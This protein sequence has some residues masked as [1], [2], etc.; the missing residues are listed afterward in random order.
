M[1]EQKPSEE[2]PDSIQQQIAAALA[3]TEVPKIYFNGFINGTTHAD[4]VLI[5][6]SNERPAIVLN[7][8][9]TV[10]KTL[11]ESLMKMVEDFEKKVGTKFKT[12]TEIDEALAK[13][14][15]QEQGQGPSHAH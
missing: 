5:L 7:A 8:S 15:A 4:C 3:S 11:A 10:T 2:R 9:F 13:Q 1:A 6:K 14:A 12:T